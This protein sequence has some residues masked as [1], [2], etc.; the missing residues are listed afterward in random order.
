MASLPILPAGPS[1]GAAAGRAQGAPAR[2]EGGG[3]D[4]AL[5]AAGGAAGAAKANPE[6]TSRAGAAD[7]RSEAPQTDAATQDGADGTTAN[8]TTADETANDAAVE[9]APAGADDAEQGGANG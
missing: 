4:A 8:V 5:K 6:E 1:V 7:K 3:F 9:A 2:S